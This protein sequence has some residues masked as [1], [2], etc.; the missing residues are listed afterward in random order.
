MD[1]TEQR[2]TLP[3]GLAVGWVVGCVLIVCTAIVLVFALFAFQDV[4]ADVLAGVNVEFVSS[5]VTIR[6]GQPSP[7]PNPTKSVPSGPSPCAI[8]REQ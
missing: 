5:S 8:A 7:A 6:V 2:L 3:G 4:I 1:G